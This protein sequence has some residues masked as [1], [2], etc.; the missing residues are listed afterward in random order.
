MSKLTREK[1]K[2][3]SE[4]NINGFKVDIGSLIYNYA[5]GDEYPKLEKTLLH[6][7][8]IF[9]KIC[10]RFFKYYD[11]SSKY[12]I[13]VR[14]YEKKDNFLISGIGKFKEIYYEEKNNKKFNFN[15][16]KKL[17]NN[18]NK[19]FEENVLKDYEEFL[20]KKKGCIL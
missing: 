3:Y 4:I 13:D 6:K 5:H 15:Y 1:I 2:K 14:E 17:C 9:V 7:N 20:N 10:I 19:E 12:F 16:L 8:N 11:K 18:V